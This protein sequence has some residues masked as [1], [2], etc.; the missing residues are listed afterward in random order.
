MLNNKSLLLISS[1]L[2]LS[3][4]SSVSGIFTDKDDRPPLEGERISVL[5][6]QK[7]LTPDTN[8]QLKAGQEFA[9]PKEWANNDWPQAGGYPNHLMQNL[10]LQIDDGL[11]K[12]WSANIGSGSSGAIPLN[13]QPII[14]KNVI[15]TLDSNSKLSAFNAENGKRIWKIDV[16]SKEEKDR[17]ISGGVSFAHGNLYVT[18][19]YDEILAISPENGEIKWRK[20]LPAPSRAAPTVINGRVFVSTINSRLVAL[21]AKDGKGLWEYTGINETTALLGAASAAANSDIVVPVFSSGEITALRVEN[22]SVAWSDNLSSVR[23]YGGGLESIS[24]IKAM[25]VIDRGIVIAISF[26]GKIAAIDSITGARIWQKEI[27]GSQTPWISGNQIYVLS[28]ENQLIAL[29]LIDGSIFWINELPR[30]ED[31]EDKD[32]PITLTGP[33]MASGKLIIAGSDGYIREINAHNGEL[34]RTIKIKKKVQIAPIIAN[35]TL[36]L[37]SD[38]GTLM[39][40]R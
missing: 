17:V 33:V 38:D 15:Y 32:D 27:S 28:S 2:A 40:Y 30:F 39:A 3:A 10:S 22:G 16:G 31:E 1:V 29:N 8:K 35:N 20:H 21:S 37:L 25:P 7:K 11:Q 6:L 24:D 18:N 14:I 13:A 5:E 12:I 23:R 4:C 26:G 9:I 36:Y 19:G 34:T